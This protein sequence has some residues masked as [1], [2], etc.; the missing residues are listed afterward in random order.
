MKAHA[1]I[2]ACLAG[3]LLA[4]AGVAGAPPDRYVQGTPSADG[5][6]KQ[7]AGREIARV[8][9]WQAAPWLEREEREKEE[10]TSVLIEELGLKPGMVVADVGAGSGYLSRRMAPLV[11]PG[12]KVI[13]VD[14]QPEMLALL[15]QTAADPRYA[16]IEPF[17]GSVDDTHLPAGSVDLAIMVDVYHELE[18]PF[19]VLDSIVRAL[20]PGG[21]VAF[22]EYRG[23]DG[24]VPIKPLHKMTERQVRREA[25]AHALTWERT[26]KRL[27]W[28]HL[29]VFRKT[30]PNG[31]PGAVR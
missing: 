24:N 4:V 27:P 12:G 14:I 1:P 13:A 6:G 21:R 29:V 17:P 22:V 19:E 3:L 18:Y 7:H 2:F 23:E 9:G 26:S 15:A 30:A 5:I 8:M 20:K 10:R 28:Q 11:A 31:A 25:A 16:N